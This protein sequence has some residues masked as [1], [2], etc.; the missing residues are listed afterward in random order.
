MEYIAHV[1]LHEIVRLPYLALWLMASVSIMVKVQCE[2]RRAV[3]A[4]E[5]ICVNTITTLSP[6]VPPLPLDHTSAKLARKEERRLTTATTRHQ[7]K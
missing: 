1:S 4:D 6:A 3:R 5:G 2:V 7:L